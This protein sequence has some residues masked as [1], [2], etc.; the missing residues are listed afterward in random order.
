MNCLQISFVCAR[1]EFSFVFVI[2]V[3]FRS[4]KYWVSFDIGERESDDDD[5]A[6][7]RIV[8]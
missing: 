8:S 7:M 3:I 2:D 5:N 1:D 6:N 4:R